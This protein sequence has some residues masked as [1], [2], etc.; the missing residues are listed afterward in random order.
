M[1]MPE[2]EE[3][4]TLTSF[5]PEST[6]KPKKKKEKPAKDKN[7]STAETLHNFPGTLILSSLALILY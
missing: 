5:I 2:A 4:T 1:V 3:T 7:T 6:M